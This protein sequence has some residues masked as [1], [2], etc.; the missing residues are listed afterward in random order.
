LRSAGF[1]RTRGGYQWPNVSKD[2]IE[3]AAK[4]RLLLKKKKK[5]GE[6]VVEPPKP[7]MDVAPMD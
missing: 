4:K 6:A 2:A 1:Q 3:L 7:S 5:S